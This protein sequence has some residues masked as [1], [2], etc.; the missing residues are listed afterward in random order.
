MERLLAEPYTEAD[1]GRETAFKAAQN[2]SKVRDWTEAVSKTLPA[3]PWARLGNPAWSNKV[4]HKILTV[5]TVWAWARLDK[6]TGNVV[7]GAGL[8][9]FGPSGSGKSSATL[10]RLVEGIG[11]VRR[12]GETGNDLQRLPS[13]LWTTEADLVRD[14]WNDAGLVERAK[15]A[16]ILIL[17]ELGF[18]G[19]DKA[20]GKPPVVLDV[21]CARYDRGKPTSATTGLTPDGLAER[22]GTGV[23]RRLTESAQTVSA[24][25]G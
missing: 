8:V 17:D 3:W 10:A 15:R 12:Y 25:G 13:I 19:G 11:K 21:V 9:L 18:S 23:Y 7:P 2:A 20:T 4:H 5:A 24:H 6:A 22:Y 16:D 14:A 1:Q